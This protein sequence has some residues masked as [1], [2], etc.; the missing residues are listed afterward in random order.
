MNFHRPM[1]FLLRSG[2][3]GG[4][5]KERGRLS[6]GYYYSCSHL[7]LPA[8]KRAK[9]NVWKYMCLWRKHWLR[10]LMQADFWAKSSPP[11]DSWSVISKCKTILNQERDSVCV[12]FSATWAYFTLSSRG[13]KLISRYRKIGLAHSVR[14]LLY[15]QFAQ[16]FLYI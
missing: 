2:V 13:S 12:Y 11:A 6:R 1:T 10:Y 16:D 15:E 9:L 3:G 8:S 7:Y 5:K 14:L 4:L